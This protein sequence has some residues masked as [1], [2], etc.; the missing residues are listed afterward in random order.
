MARSP[1][2]VDEIDTLRWFDPASQRATGESPDRAV[3]PPAREAI[4]E[5]GKELGMV[6]QFDAPAKPDDLP[7][8]QDDIEDLAAGLPNPHL[9]FYLPQIYQRPDSLLHYLPENTLLF[10]DDWVTLQQTIQESPKTG[11]IPSLESSRKTSNAFSAL[12]RHLFKRN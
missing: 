2:V 9:E 11:S 6:F 4:P 8:W 10:V 5:D 7:A 1:E 12:P 3:I